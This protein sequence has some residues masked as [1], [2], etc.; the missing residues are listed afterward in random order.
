MA[1]KASPNIKTTKNYKPEPRQGKWLQFYNQ[2]KAS[3]R[4]S[5]NLI[6]MV[7]EVVLNHFCKLAKNKNIVKNWLVVKIKSVFSQNFKQI[8]ISKMSTH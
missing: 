5:N 3:L 8:R 1:A 4:Y 2:I 7:A 6:L